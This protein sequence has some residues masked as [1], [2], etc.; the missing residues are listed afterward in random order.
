M[1]QRDMERNSVIR[2]LTHWIEAIFA[3]AFRMLGGVPPRHMMRLLMP[4]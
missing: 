4:F 1:L 2:R 3:P